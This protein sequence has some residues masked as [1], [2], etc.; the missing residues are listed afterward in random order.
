MLIMMW[1]GQMAKNQEQNQ[2]IID[3]NVNPDRNLWII[4]AVLLL[5]AVAALPFI[6]RQ[7]EILHAIAAACMT[8]ISG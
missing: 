4:W 2:Q 7:S 3:S 6:S 5:I 8:L 1:I